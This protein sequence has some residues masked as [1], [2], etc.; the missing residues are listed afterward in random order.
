MHSH[1]IQS[2]DPSVESLLGQALS[3]EYSLA[4][5]VR[6]PGISLQDLAEAADLMWPES[7]V[8]EQ[9]EI[10]LKYEGYIVRQREEIARMQQYVNQ[11]IPVDIDYD[12]IGGLSNEVRQ[13]LNDARP[14][15]IGQASRIAGVTPAAVSLL[16]V[17]IKKLGDVRHRQVTAHA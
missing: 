17:H 12:V 14:E 6:R 5:L 15:T 8:N 4:D 7:E 1:W 16:L 9:V 2:G 13:K 11:P 10:D 3:H